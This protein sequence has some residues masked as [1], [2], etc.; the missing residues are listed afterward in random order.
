MDN[1]EEHKKAFVS[2]RSDLLAEWE[3][4]NNE[5]WP[6]YGKAVMT[7]RGRVVRAPGNTYNVLKIIPLASGGPLTWFNIRNEKEVKEGNEIYNCF[8]NDDFC[9]RGDGACYISS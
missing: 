3:E 9:F 1:I 8:G 2:I 4:N 7:M 6:K 5:Q